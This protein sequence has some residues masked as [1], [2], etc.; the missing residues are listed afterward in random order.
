MAERPI[1]ARPIWRR[2]AALAFA[3]L[4]VTSLVGV[5]AAQPSTKDRLAAAE[6]EVKRLL[7]QIRDGQ[8]KLDQL[9]REAGRL[10]AK[11]DEAEARWEE[12][13]EQLR[14]T[15]HALI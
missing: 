8:I 11:V 2:F 5:A 13:T 7:G 15:R 12:I 6:A 1:G 9:S 14:V 10:A 4:L 3:F